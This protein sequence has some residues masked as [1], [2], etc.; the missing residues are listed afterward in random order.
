MELIESHAAHGC[1]RGGPDG[2]RAHNV[3]EKIKITTVKD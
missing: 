2:R 3:T 1:A